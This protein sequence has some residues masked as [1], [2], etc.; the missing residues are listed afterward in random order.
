VF[1]RQGQ[2]LLPLAFGEI[3]GHPDKRTIFPRAKDHPLS[4]V[5][6]RAV[7]VF[8]ALPY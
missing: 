8:L 6:P 7:G 1:W 5:P 4:Q 3:A 2:G